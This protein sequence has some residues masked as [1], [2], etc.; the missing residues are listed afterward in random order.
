MYTRSVRMVNEFKDIDNWCTYMLNRRGLGCTLF[1]MWL[2]TIV[3][4]V[5]KSVA[6]VVY[7]CQL[8]YKH[9]KL[10]GTGL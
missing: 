1:V 8:V 2:T 4:R 3:N 10:A 6:A 5:V 7:D 9:C